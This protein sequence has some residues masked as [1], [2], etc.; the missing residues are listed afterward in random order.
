LI[1]GETSSGAAV[2]EARIRLQEDLLGVLRQA[3]LELCRS[4]RFLS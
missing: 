1:G 4:G 3:A 2:D